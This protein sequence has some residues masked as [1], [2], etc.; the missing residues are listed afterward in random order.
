MTSLKQL[1][2]L[3]LRYEW[4]ILLCLLP[5]ALLPTLARLWPLLFIPLLWLMRKWVDGRFFRKTPLDWPIWG[6]LLTLVV[7]VYATDDLLAS[8]PK[9]VGLLYG[10]AVF[11]AAVAF[12]SQGERR[13][14]TA[15]LALVGCGLIVAGLGVLG[16]RWTNKFDWLDAVLARFPERVLTLPAAEGGISPNE[17]A[18]VLLWILP[19]GVALSLAL[20]RY[21]LPFKRPAWQAGGIALFVWGA[22]LVMLAIVVLTQSRGGLLGLAA[23]LG[24]MLLLLV[25][26][27]HW[28]LALGLVLGGLV[29]GAAVWQTNQEPL[30]TFLIEQS[31]LRLR[32]EEQR[33]ETLAGRI[34]IWERAVYGIQDFAL[35]GMGMNRFRTLVFAYYPTFFLPR[36]SDFA[37]AHN[38]FLQAGLDLGILGLLF[39]AALW[40]GVT[41][42]AWLS[43]QHGRTVWQQAL[44]LGI[45]GALAAYFVYG[46]V[47]AV[48]LGARPGFIFWLLLA[49]T[50]AHYAQVYSANHADNNS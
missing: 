35:T 3:V 40:L 45:M 11:Y 4:F 12:A 15:V 39:Y 49:V 50:A 31:G 27:V 43:W 25:A 44:A 38:H 18:G 20:L 14:W 23:G 33:I 10:L 19:I 28:W 7:S 17:V 46:L 34:Q 2:R 29:L 36:D 13:M 24:L 30:A 22:T 16:I 6:L 26:R 41:A 47:D 5:F 8:L 42:V 37:H 48:A 1:C 9:V 32:G 21:G